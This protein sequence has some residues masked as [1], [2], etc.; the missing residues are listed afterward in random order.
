MKRQRLIAL[1]VL[2]VLIFNYPI[3]SLFSVETLLFGVP[4]QYLYL[5]GIWGAFVWLLARIVEGPEED[6]PHDTSDISPE[7]SNAQPLAND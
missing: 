2:G 7:M 3:L 6:V 5:F 4:V 1:F